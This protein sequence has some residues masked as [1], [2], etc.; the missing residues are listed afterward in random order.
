[1]PGRGAHPVGWRVLWGL[2]PVSRFCACR[3]IAVGVFSKQAVFQG[4]G[5]VGRQQAWLHQQDP[6]NSESLV[7][8]G[9]SVWEIMLNVYFSPNEESSVV[10]EDWKYSGRQMF[11]CKAGSP[12][13]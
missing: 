13:F 7:P 11:M 1:M 3:E 9:L 12:F 2:R 10:G 5:V 8:G 4:V 6:R